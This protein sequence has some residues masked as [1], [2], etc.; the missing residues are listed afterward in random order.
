MFSEWFP[1]TVEN[2]CVECSDEQKMGFDEIIKYLFE[3][4]KKC[5]EENRRNILS[6]NTTLYD[7]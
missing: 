7:F 2:E 6:E 3:N 4:K 1:E 5:M